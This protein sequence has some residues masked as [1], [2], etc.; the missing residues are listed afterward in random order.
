[1]GVSNGQYPTKDDPANIGYTSEDRIRVDAEL[2]IGMLRKIIYLSNN[3]HFNYKSDSTLLLTRVT[4]ETTIK[5]ETSPFIF[6]IWDNTLIK[7]SRYHYL[8][9]ELLRKTQF[10]VKLGEPHSCAI[11]GAKDEE[12]EDEVIEETEEVIEETEEV[13]E[14]N[15]KNQ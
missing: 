14:E 2:T 3:H 9:C 4:E 8:M 10:E 12:Q 13:I 11:C 7:S 15:R 6:R 5:E 1:M